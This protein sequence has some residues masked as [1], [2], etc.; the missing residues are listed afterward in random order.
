MNT[1]IK[2][3]CSV[4]IILI[5]G[6]CND[7]LDRVPLDS[8]STETFWQ[9]PEQAELW[10]NNLY[11][12]LGD[13]NDCR[14]EAFSDDAFGRASTGLNNIALGIFEP[15]DPDVQNQWN[16]RKIRESL[17]FFE[18]IDRVPGISQN[19]L[20]ELSGQAN[21]VLA[22]RYFRMMIFYRDIPLVT[23]PLSVAESD[24]PKSPKEEVLAYILERLDMAI[25]QLPLTWPSSEAGRITKGA[26]LALKARVLLYNER[27]AEAAQTAKQVMD[28]GIYELHPNFEELFMEAFNNATKESILET[29]Y[30]ENAR[31]HSLGRTYNYRSIDGFALIQ[32]MKE[33][34]EAFPMADGLPIDESPLYNPSNPFENRDPRFYATFNYPGRTMN[35]ITFDPINDPLDKSFTFTYLFYRKY[36]TDFVRGEKIN[37]YKNWYVFRYAEVLLM[38]A[39]AKNEASG[40]ESSIY[41][42]LDLLRS[43][44]GMP[45]VDR[46]RYSTQETLREFIRNERRIELAGEGLRSF[47]IIRWRIAEDVLN[48]QFTSME[49]P[50]WLP[51]INIHTRVFLP[52]RHYVWPIPQT[53]IDRA[54]Q[55]E[56]H[57]EWK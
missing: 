10:V 7:F 8:P 3:I 31:E 25:N 55:L 13:V 57:P 38:Y 51:L 15:N 40:P 42:A 50:D 17:E 32:P 4:T 43:R 28:L 23:R 29:Q 48:G 35:G 11:N 22:Y 47:D 53:A 26:A 2:T 49:V 1:A 52:N 56:Q 5:M 24:I 39:E 20:N 30:A 33:L 6:A 54:T 19:R 9:T 27:W 45:P 37:L 21:F 36:V 46:A 14:F 44:A 12:G 41:D 18:N 34:G 16:Y